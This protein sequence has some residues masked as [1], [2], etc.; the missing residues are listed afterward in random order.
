MSAPTTL[1]LDDG[2]TVQD[3][4]RALLYTGFAVS[5]TIIPGHFVIKPAQRRLPQNVIDLSIFHRR[6]AE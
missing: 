5:D 2:V 3:I 6:Q 4:A 1:I